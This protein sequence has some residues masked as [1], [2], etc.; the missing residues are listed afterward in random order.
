M[1]RKPWIT[2][3][4]TALLL[5]AGWAGSWA[6]S[7]EATSLREVYAATNAAVVTVFTSEVFLLVDEY[8]QVTKLEHEAAGVI[9]SNEGDLLT[10]SHPVETADRI[11]V[12]LHDGKIVAARVIASEPAADVALLRLEEFP[13][14]AG[15]ARLGDSDH[16]QVGDDIFIT[17]AP[18]GV[19]HF[20]SVGRL[21][22]R[23][24]PDQVGADLTL[25]EFF[26][27]DAHISQG[28]S[29]A[30]MFNL[31]GEVIG[32]VTH[33][34]GQQE[35][36]ARVG[37]GA[38]SNAAQR[39]LIEQRS[40]WGGF[41]GTWLTGLLAPALNVPQERGLLVQRIAKHSPAAL[42][43]LRAGS[44]ASIVGGVPLLLGGDII[45][46]IQGVSLEDEEGYEKARERLSHLETGETMAMKVMR[47][48]EIV[49]LSALVPARD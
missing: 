5:V 19:E 42:L 37:F 38:T 15:V 22:A 48:G 13:A 18:H 23:S 29:G 31:D 26:A 11:S 33:T 39:L 7:A 12:K 45:V 1:E 16:M 41:S 40:F 2:P 4:I 30:P 27:T 28:T 47:E 24:R 9:I 49:E 21:S 44:L 3:W 8:P 43:G 10:A 14:S 25:G 46:S 32:I 6:A 17:G 20:L 36:G 34:M 35:A